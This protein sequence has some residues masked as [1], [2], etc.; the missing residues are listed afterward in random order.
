MSVTL[1]VPYSA[2]GQENGGVK[3]DV[4]AQSA[5]PG[6]PVRMYL[7]GR[8]REALDGYG[9]T[10]GAAR[11]GAGRLARYD[12]QTEMALFDLDGSGGLSAFT[13]P[14]LS[15]AT[16]TAVGRLY[17]V[18]G[19][20]VS[21]IAL[22]G[23]DV[24]RYFRLSGNA[25]A[26]GLDMPV[27]T[28]TVAATAHRS[29]WCRE[30]EWIAPKEPA[31]GLPEGTCTDDEDERDGAAYWF[32]L[33]RHG[34]LVEEFSLTLAETDALDEVVDYGQVWAQLS[35]NTL[36]DLDLWVI[37]PCGNKIWFADMEGTCNGLIGTLDIDANAGMGSN[38]T[39]EPVERI[40]WESPP[41]GS[42]QVY[43]SFYVSDVPGKTV[44]FNLLV[45]TG[46]GVTAYN[47]T[48][49]IGEGHNNDYKLMALFTY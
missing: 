42:Y 17:H 19:N 16:V 41:R 31:S 15:L 26:A 9:L 7:W 37:D 27:L 39:N 12:G 6:E 28:G 32:F 8:S 33:M 2:S 20:A 13:W 4:P 36:D 1:L 11:L 14:V 47:D 38:V 30:W 10:Q 25:L 29:P 21:L 23:E 45:Q 43:V 3:M 34:V 49:T 24:T 18:A 5:D 22:P 35:W 48:I 44:S 46:R 40:A